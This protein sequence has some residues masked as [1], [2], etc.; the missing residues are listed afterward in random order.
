MHARAHVFALVR[1][2]KCMHVSDPCTCAHGCVWSGVEN[3]RKAAQM[4]DGTTRPIPA[5]PPTGSANA[6]RK[7]GQLLV[8]PG[9]ENQG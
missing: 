6:A 3:D 2:C 8:R 1:M 5:S 7:E 4:K 9:L